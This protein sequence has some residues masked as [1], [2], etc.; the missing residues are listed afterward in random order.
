MSETVVGA[1]DLDEAVIDVAV[2]G[3][4]LHAVRWG[5]ADPDAPV[6]LALHGVTANH[7]CW[8]PTAR[9]L[10][11]CRFLAPDLRG[12]GGSGALPGPF[13]M[14]AHAD[15]AVALLDAQQVDKA[16]VVG[17]SMGGF[18]AL[19]FAQ[20]HPERVERLLLVDGG[21]PMP[22]SPGLDP[23]AALQ[24]VIGPAAQ[25]LSMTFRS[26]EGYLDLWRQHPAMA[27]WNDDIARYLHYDL[28]GAEPELR[29]SCSIDAVR[30]DTIDLTTGTALVEALALLTDP[31]RPVPLLRAPFGLMAEPGGLYT[32]EVVAGWA[33]A[34]PALD[35]TAVP[36]TNHYSILLGSDGA[37]AVAGAIRSLAAGQQG[38]QHEHSDA[39]EGS[40]GRDR[41]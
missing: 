41:H 36:G 35:V 16:V 38:Q 13:G 23:D 2:A 28:V 33:G 22:L 15:D 1:G 4:T 10:P 20:R 9:R 40:D 6:V 8:A 7:L 18:A 3:G 19:V 32:P 30:G 25:R 29:S 27:D 37:D 11:E 17:H 26:R 31:A 21:P 5:S 34:F 12:R 39:K 14:A 24:A